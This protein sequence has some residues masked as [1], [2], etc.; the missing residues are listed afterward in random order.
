MD[1]IVDAHHLGTPERRWRR[2]GRLGRLDRLDVGRPRQVV[3]VAPHPDDEVFGAGGLIRQ[4]ALAGAAVRVLAVTDGEASRPGSPAALRERRHA[5][6]L[7]GLRRLGAG[8]ALVASLG[9]PDGR[10]GD[11]L[12]ELHAALED[13]LHGADLVVAPW[14]HDG[15]PDHDACGAV[16]S[17]VAGDVGVRHLGYLVWAW[18]WADPSSDD[19]PWTDC[20]RLDLG[21]VTHARKWWGTRAFRTQTR[22]YR[23]T[24]ASPPVLPRAVLRRL[25]RRIEVFVEDGTD[26]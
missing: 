20:R 25:R 1:L 7:V 4:L 24:P 17:E 18:H 21:P 22:P 23:G 8:S 2:S 6:T 9:L 26:P 19:I 11:H 14:R 5:E 16:A 15:H 13:Q 12:D 3:V 10:V